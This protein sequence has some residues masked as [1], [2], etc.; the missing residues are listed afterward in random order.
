MK[1]L[2]EQKPKNMRELRAHLKTVKKINELEEQYQAYTD[3]ALQHKTIEFK[4][5]L[6][7][8]RNRT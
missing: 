4:E 7:K 6:K 8:R 2:L 5:R 3:E 1:D